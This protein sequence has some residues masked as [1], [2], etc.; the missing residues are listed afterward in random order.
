M[1]V[2]KTESLLQYIG[3]DRNGEIMSTRIDRRRIPKHN[4]QYAPWG[5]KSIGLAKMLKTAID[6]MV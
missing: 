6:H 5:R 4:L 1:T 2:L 3:K